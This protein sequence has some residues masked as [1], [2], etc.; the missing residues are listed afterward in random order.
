MES[1]IAEAGFTTEIPI[2]HSDG[3]YLAKVVGSQI[4]EIVEVTRKS[5]LDERVV[6]ESNKD[7]RFLT[8]AEPFNVTNQR[9]VVA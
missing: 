6:V 2:F 8:P 4:T 1:L 3:T 7:D 9:C 5:S